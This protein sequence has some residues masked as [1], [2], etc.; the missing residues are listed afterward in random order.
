MDNEEAK[1]LW[2]R[3]MKQAEA[4]AFSQALILL[5]EL[6]QA[7]PN[8]RKVMLQRALCLVELGRVNDAQV[9]YTKLSGKV[10]DDQ[11]KE[12]LAKIES[13]RQSSEMPTPPIRHTSSGGQPQNMLT[14]ESVHP[15]G[16]GETTI[17][18][19][20]L[21]GIFRTAD[22]LTLITPDG[23]PKEATIKRIGAIE[24]PLNLVRAGQQAPILL[25]VEVQN[26]VPGSQATAATT[27]ASYAATVVVA[28]GP[29]ESTAAEHATPEL[30]KAERAIKKHD[31]ADAKD[32][33]KDYLQNDPRNT[34]AYRLLAQ[35]YL[36]GGQGI[37]DVKKSLDCIRK[38]YELG[39]AEDPVVID[40]LAAALAANGEAGQGLRFLERLHGANLGVEARMALAQRIFDFRDQHRLGHVW[41]FADSFDEVIF[42]SGN[43]QEIVKALGNKTVPL[44]AK[45]RRDKVGEWLN[46]E[47]ALG[48]ELP[49]IAALY[50]PA[51]KRERLMLPL[52]L[53]VILLLA[54][55]IVLLLLR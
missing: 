3:A 37:Q 8:S 46:I 12:L 25:D 51:K 48:P 13:A 20:V 41:E 16:T 40:I 53:A 26:V 9:C 33:L 6:D 14:I 27:A 21:Q 42:E 43:A 17:M 10:D 28:D 55:I 50:Q 1:T 15:T 7:R 22:K 34:F 35:V 23:L 24:T 39:G 52:L 5:D 38:A 30:A 36:A 44:D 54:I 19:R 18:G 4:E 45:C 31:Y 32:R 11:L 47:A 29:G 2:S 49:E